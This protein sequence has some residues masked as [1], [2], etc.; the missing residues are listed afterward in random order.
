MDEEIRMRRRVCKKKD[1]VDRE[2]ESKP[3]RL[4][5]KMCDKHT[6]CACRK[7]MSSVR[8]N[9]DKLKKLEDI[10]MKFKNKECV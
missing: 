9:D 5:K 4:Q 10:F 1:Y 7:K 8:A 6:S 3:K 2:R